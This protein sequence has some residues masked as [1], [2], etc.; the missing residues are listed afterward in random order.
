MSA[1]LPAL[2]FDLDGTLTDSKPGILACLRQVLDDRN[3]G[4]C[5]PLDR[6]VGPPVEEWAVALLPNGTEEERIALARDYRAYYGQKG[7]NNNSVF[8]GV[9]EMLAQLHA[10]GFP[11]Y[12]CTS[13]VQHFA[14]QILDLF[15]LSPFFTAIYGDKA[16]YPD[17]SKPVLLARLLAE[18]GLGSQSAGAH[19]LWMIGDR[20]YD[21][22]AARANGIPS[23]AAGW[24]YG[25]PQEFAQA[26][27]IAPT[28]ANVFA[29]VAPR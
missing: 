22:D 3:M 21:F 7:W 13:K 23:V 15:E 17:H 10:Q 9:R 20:T 14:V 28:P 5:G 25:T 19:S 11:L 26:T 8:P 27:A 2:I 16:E 18:S 29:L 12:V 24:G 1:S 6:F 4:D